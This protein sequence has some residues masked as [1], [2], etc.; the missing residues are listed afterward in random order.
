GTPGRIR[1]CDPLLRCNL[2]LSAVFPY[3][4]C[5]PKP[6]HLS[7]GEIPLFHATET[8]Q[9]PTTTQQGTMRNTR[10]SRS[11]LASMKG[12]LLK[13]LTETTYLRRELS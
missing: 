3:L 1:N 9:Y 4:E 6:V 12:V 10:S 11:H 13:L 7:S 5:Q 8:E 2:A